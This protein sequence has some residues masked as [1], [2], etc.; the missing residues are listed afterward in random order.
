M[1]AIPMDYTPKISVI[2]PT[3]NR[4]ATIRYCLESVISQTYPAH[5]IIVVDD[6]STDDTLS[7]VASFNNE[8]IK[9]VSLHQKGGAQVARNLGI[10][11]ASGDWIAFQDSDDTWRADKLEKQVKALEKAGFPDNIV[12]HSECQAFRTKDGSFVDFPINRVDG[13]NVYR[14]LLASPAPLFPTILTSKK[15]LEYIGK[16]DVEVPSYQEWDTVIRLSKNCRFIHLTEPLFIYHLH[17]GATISKDRTKEIQGYSFIRRKFKSEIISELGP[18]FFHI[19]YIWNCLRA[20]EE[21]LD[22]IADK[23]L[24]EQ[25]GSKTLL[26]YLIQTSRSLNLSNALL[27][28]VSM[29]RHLVTRKYNDNKN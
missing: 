21:D 23:I 12:V 24:A 4:S 11:H 15:A 16:L 26:W 20:Y 7:V 5:E 3:F 10:E 6:C 25:Y 27:K 22:D 13:D 28:I 8:I 19:D 9:V 1:P 29:L 2:I 14:Q 17:E 18:F